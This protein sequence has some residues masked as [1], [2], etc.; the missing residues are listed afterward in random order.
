MS[1]S[2]REFLRWCLGSGALLLAGSPALAQQ[3]SRPRYE[4]LDVLPF[5]GEGRNFIGVAAGAG[6]NGRRAF[7]TST[8]TSK[9]LIVPN[10]RFFIRTRYPEGLDPAM[11]WQLSLEGSVEAQR[12]ERADQRALRTHQRLSHRQLAKLLGVD[13]G[14]VF[15]PPPLIDENA[16]NHGDSSVASR[17]RHPSGQDFQPVGAQF[18]MRAFKLAP[19]SELP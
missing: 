3:G 2:R 7:D 13:A 5:H 15:T 18:V 17:N 16:S 19:C 8:L 11:P 4:L 10:D 6:L 14:S 12:A 1:T 9:K